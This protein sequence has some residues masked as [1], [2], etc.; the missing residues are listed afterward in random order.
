M[1]KPPPTQWR[2]MQSKL[3]KWLKEQRPKEI[4]QYEE[5]GYIVKVFEPRWA[6]GDLR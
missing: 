4:G 3:N 6:S 1:P 2:L 5:N